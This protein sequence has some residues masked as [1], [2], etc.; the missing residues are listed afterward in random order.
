MPA[1][2]VP[3]QGPLNLPPMPPPQ[4]PTLGERPP[5]Q[6]ARLLSE[7]GGSLGLRQIPYVGDVFSA[8]GGL[9]I[10][11]RD[12]L[13]QVNYL[14]SRALLSPTLRPLLLRHLGATGGV[15]RPELIGA[16]SG[17]LTHEV[18]RRGLHTTDAADGPVDRQ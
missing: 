18:E 4:Q 15:V 6:W 14:L 12:V 17:G 10:L 9:H 13:P 8:L 5:V 16:L 7:L 11:K 1:V 3:G 2:Q